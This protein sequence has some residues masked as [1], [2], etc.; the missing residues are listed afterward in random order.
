MP[1]CKDHRFHATL[2]E[3]EACIKHRGS[4]HF[5]NLTTESRYQRRQ[6]GGGLQVQVE[7]AGEQDIVR[8]SHPSTPVPSSPASSQATTRPGLA[9]A[10]QDHPQPPSAMGDGVMQPPQPLVTSQASSRGVSVATAPAHLQLGLPIKLREPAQPRQM[11]PPR[12]ESET[13]AA[14]L[15]QLLPAVSQVSSGSQPI[16]RWLDGVPSPRHTTGQHHNGEQIVTSTQAN[17]E[18]LPGAEIDGAARDVNQPDGLETVAA[19]AYA[20]EQRRGCIPTQR[21]WYE[22]SNLRAIYPVVAPATLC[23]IIAF[24]LVFY[25]AMLDEQRYP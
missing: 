4:S 19:S 11:D 22:S 10:A 12:R 18:R 9:P 20:G 7:E 16:M 15:A 3:A 2:A 8:E 5:S 1:H 25:L 24:V 23:A 13:A 6:L 17:S 14:G 21:P